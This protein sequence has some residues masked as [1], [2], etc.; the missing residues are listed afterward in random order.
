MRLR[1]RSSGSQ[2][3]ARL[4]RDR[5]P[6]SRPSH[7]GVLTSWL[8]QGLRMG[9]CPLCRVG[10]KADR[11]YIW[12][13]FDEGADRG[14][15][16]DELT[17]AYGFC[18]EHID[19]LCRIEVDGMHSTLGVSTMLVD[20]FTGIVHELDELDCDSPFQRSTCPACD[21]RHERLATN[22]Q[23]LLDEI[24]TNPGLRE[25]F[26]QSPGLCF[27]HFELVWNLTQ[28]DDERRLLWRTQ[29]AAASRLLSELREH[30]R[31]QDHRFRS[32]P[33]GAEHDSWRRAIF[34]TT[35]WPPPAESAGEPE[36]PR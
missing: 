7:P 32:E 34:M 5:V 31:K 29:H 13:F 10:H 16:I 2:P 26:E 22:A 21:N 17:R 12:H 24:A 23:Y 6:P 18:Q 19:M 1:L 27:G 9:I 11:E 20:V 8:R 25:T 28:S 33:K 30:V 14:E 15:S 35:G 4:R 3:R 36:T